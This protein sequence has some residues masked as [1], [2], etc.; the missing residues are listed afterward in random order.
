METKILE[1]CRLL[2]QGGLRISFTQIADVLKATATLGFERSNFYQ[3]LSC[4]LVCDQADQPLFDKL[5][6]LYFYTL[7][8]VDDHHAAN[9]PAADEPETVAQL[10]ATASGM[11]M[12]RGAGASPM[13]LLV[14]AVCESDYQ[15]LQNI[16]KVAMKSLGPLESTALHDKEQ[17][18]VEARV[19]IGWYEAVNRLNRIRELEKV[20]DLIFIRW[21]AALHYL[22][23]QITELLDDYFVRHFGLNA[24]D[25]IAA[26]ANL[27]E[28]EFYR[29]TDDETDEIRKRITKLARRLASKYSRRYRRSKRG[30]IDLRR[31][32]RQAL[33]TGG[34]PV[35]LKYRA[36][37]VSK[38]DLIILCDV[39]GSVSLFSEFMLQLVYTIQS[40]FRAVRSFLFVDKIDEV[41]TYFV[42]CELEDALAAA[43]A[44]GQYS[45]SGFSDIGRVFR[46]FTEKYLLGVSPKSTVLILGDAKNNWHLDEREC[47]RQIVEHTRKVFW[48]NPQPRETWGQDDS[49]MKIYAPL[50]HQVFE[51][52]NLRQLED[53]IRAIL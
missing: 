43:F 9:K 10:V 51:C 12:G 49:I 30:D 44:G 39:S 17:L 13:L 35:H 32:I 34:K 27:H 48:F 33:R 28:K 23:Q 42:H 52:R 21:T 40:R 31:T 50:C 18:L 47:F 14:K 1:F 38:P 20:S 15:L 53:V 24:L 3:A 16:A 8:S 29:L 5:F 41:T 26:A 2:R 46:L 22:E 25:E 45:Y 7:H 37:V 6:R 36:K 4:I 11:G 19:G